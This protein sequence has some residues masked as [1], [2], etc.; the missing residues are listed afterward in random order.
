MPCII[1]VWQ[2]R[3]SLTNFKRLLALVYLPAS[4]FQG[5]GK[6]EDIPEQLEAHKMPDSSFSYPNL[7][8]IFERM[9]CNMVEAL[10]LVGMNKE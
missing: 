7:L 8:R 1:R 5:N 2:L 10:G 9:S 3:R 4:L 6:L